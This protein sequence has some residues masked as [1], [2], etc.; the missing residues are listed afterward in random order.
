V[1]LCPKTE[2]P[3]LV[4]LDTDRE[5]PEKQ[6]LAANKETDKQ[7]SKTEV[8]RASNKETASEKQKNPDPNFLKMLA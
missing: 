7:L 8:P 2:V 6:L 3:F 4:S 1:T 5:F